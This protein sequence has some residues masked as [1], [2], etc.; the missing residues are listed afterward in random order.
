MPQKRWLWLSL[1]VLTL[2]QVTKMA[3]DQYLRYHE[4][5][6]VF[7]GFNLTLVYNPGAAFSFLADQ[8]GW[9]RWFF[10]LLA[11]AVSVVLIIWLLRLSAREGVL[12]AGLSLIVGGAVGNLIDRLL[13][14]HVIDFLD[15]YYQRWHWPAFNL[16][17]SAIFLGVALLLYD[18]L[19]LEP[20]RCRDDEKNGADGGGGDT[21]SHG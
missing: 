5:V 14:G 4:P 9:Q 17:D 3:A 18:A 16:A 7:P 19:L 6:P 10:V 2:D 11:L 12:A 1:V 20:R 15:F 8:G 13:Y 21:P